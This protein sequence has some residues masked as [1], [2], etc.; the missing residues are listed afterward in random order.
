MH[1]S[2]LKPWVERANSC[3]ICRA[4]FNMVE[5]RDFLNGPTTSSYAVQNK[6]QEAELDPSMLIEE[7]LFDGAEEDEPCIICSTID[8][9]ME[10]MYCDGCD[11]TVHVFCAG[12]GDCP[13]VW[14]C[15]GCLEDLDNNRELGL[16]DFG[17]HSTRARTRQGRGSRARRTA[18]GTAWARV[19][20][21]VWDRLNL[22]LDFPFDDDAPTINS[23]AVAAQRREFN[24]WQRRF[25]VASRQGAGNRFR[26]TAA[27]LL[28]PHTAHSA[29]RLDKAPESHDELR[30]WNAFDKA[31][32]LQ[33]E[34]SRPYIT[35]NRRKRKSTRSPGS[36]ASAQDD[37]QQRE[38]DEP[39]RK[40]KRPRTRR[41]NQLQGSAAPTAESSTTAMQRGTGN[42]TIADK[43]QSEG[44]SFLTALLQEVEKQAAPGP[45]STESP[46]PKQLSDGQQSPLLPSPLGS[47]MGSPSG[48]ATPRGSS[49]T[50]PPQPRPSSP[51]PLTS[52]VG[53]ARSPI[54]NTF[55]PETHT[56]VRGRIQAQQ[57]QA[58][59]PNQPNPPPPQSPSSPANDNGSRSRN[60]SPSRNM[61]YST[62]REI[63]RMVKAALA[64]RYRDQEVTKD[65]YTDI[66]REVSRMLYDKIGDARGL[67][68]QEERDKWQ[69]V[70]NEEVERAV[71]KF[72]EGSRVVNKS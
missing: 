1:D 9:N 35:P 36:R 48:Y 63:Q 56:R 59:Q 69:K 68:E 52:M 67:E 4:N 5:L 17:V 24:A 14:Y 2:C 34:S 31:R 10:V 57:Q 42:G 66:N 47:P 19:W 30:A 45:T 25:Q 38:P 33:E 28:D 3:P 26:D 32:E 55:S 60:M 51:M 71:E 16:P 22:D 70:A 37:V 54:S 8:N 12:L 46:E 20:Q 64:P 49:V 29:S 13:D 72:F 39:E 58:N 65:Q 18:R 53:P 27:T 6:Q 7:D 40:L 43:V 50:P 15:D 44:P 61:S 21:S 23:R 41:N 11:K 62:K